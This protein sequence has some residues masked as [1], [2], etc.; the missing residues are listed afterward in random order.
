ME[1]PR[2]ERFFFKAIILFLDFSKGFCLKRQ[3]DRNFLLNF[4]L[5]NSTD[6]S[7]VFG[8][9]S[10]RLFSFNFAKPF[11]KKA[12]KIFSDK[13]Q[14]N[15]FSF[16][17]HLSSINKKLISHQQVQQTMHTQLSFQTAKDLIPNCLEI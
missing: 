7:S 3:I 17:N 5:E 4:F 8:C 15:F 1:K 11:L 9:P 6:F 12:S 10:L 2:F 14:R 13:T 16:F